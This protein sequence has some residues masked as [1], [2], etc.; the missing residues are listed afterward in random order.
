MPEVA[1]PPFDADRVLA[2]PRRV[3]AVAQIVI[4]RQ[5]ARRQTQLVVQ[6]AGHREVVL[7]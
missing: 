2:M 7:I 1:R 4:A 5:E 6:G 3:V